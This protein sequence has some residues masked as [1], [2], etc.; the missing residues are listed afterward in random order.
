MVLQVHSAQLTI[1]VILQIFT[2]LW[3]IVYNMSVS[4]ILGKNEDVGHN[5]SSGGNADRASGDDEAKAQGEEQQSDADDETSE[6]EEGSLQIFHYLLDFA[7]CCD[8]HNN[9]L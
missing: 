5:A 6:S 8:H 2:S 4:D 1:S 9:N 3:V 7:S